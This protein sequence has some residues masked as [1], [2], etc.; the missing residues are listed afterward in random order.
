MSTAS[1]TG[2]ITSSTTES[3]IV[4]GGKTIII[5]LIGDTWI[6]GSISQWADEIGFAW[7]DDGTEVWEDD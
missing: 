6:P 3:D 2:T 5:T 1:I 7:K 4:S